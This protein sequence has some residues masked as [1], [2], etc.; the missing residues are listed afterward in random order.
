MNNIF[1]DPEIE[2]YMVEKYGPN[3]AQ[4]AQANYQ[5]QMNRSNDAA[6]LS[7][8]GDVIAGQKVGSNNPYFQNLNDRA[9]A[10]MDKMAQERKNVVDQYLKQKYFDAQLKD[11]EEERKWRE[12][13]SK[14]DREFK[15]QDRAD[16]R[17]LNQDTKQ[18]ITNARNEALNEKYIQNLSTAVKGAQEPLMQFQSLETALGAPIESFTKD[19]NGNLVDAKGDVVDLPGVSMWGVG[20]VSAYSPE[21]RNLQGNI[22][23]VLNAE[24]KDMSGAT[25]TNNEMERIKMAFQTGKYNTEA[26]M[27]AALGEFKRAAVD[28]LKSREAGY[29]PEIVQEYA[30]RGGR[31]SL[32]YK[33]IPKK[34]PET[35]ADIE[36]QMS[37][38]RQK[39]IQELRQKVGGKYGSN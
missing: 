21:A 24:I 9:Q 12:E 38:E 22:Q 32:S 15:K 5:S 27:I 7:N 3:Y 14:I 1:N 2:K 4:D 8:I 17:K 19:K 28:E 23:K 35:Q 30:K 16:A 34:N 31:T 18:E 25:V 26:E 11:K 39:R 20:R 37:Q 33:D 13:Q 10:G 29:K 6:L 36:E